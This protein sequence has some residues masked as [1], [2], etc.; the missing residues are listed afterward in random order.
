MP[1][2]VH[3][4]TVNL[5]E[6][7][8]PIYIGGGLLDDDTILKPHLGVGPHVIITNT[9][10]ASLYLSRVEKL[11]GDIP[12]H[13]ITIE[14]GEE[15]KTLDTFNDIIT[16]LLE[17]GAHRKS[18]L[19]ALGGG[20]V[21]DIV[22]FVSASYRRGT[23][24]IQIPTTL[25]AQVDASVGG[26][27]A[28]NHR[29]G[30]NMI[31]AFHQP[32]A[33]VIDTNTLDSLPERHYLAGV[34]EIIKYGL[35]ADEKLFGTIEDSLSDVLARDARILNTLITRS[36][37][38]KADIVAQDE[39]ETG[40]ARMLLNLGHTFGHAIETLLGHGTWLHGEA[41]ACGLV[42]ATQFSQAQGLIDEAQCERAITLIK[43]AGLPSELPEQISTDKMLE[44]MSRDKKNIGAQQTLVLIKS[45][46]DAFVAPDCDTNALRA[47]LDSL[48]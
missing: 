11:L 16:Q 5:K 33:V 24:F 46:G 30:K 27:T 14:D 32:A 26:K 40:G 35:I 45:I 44:A 21:G 23:S 1:N 34:A 39:H 31:G 8:Y 38:I 3:K 41:V 10:V 4:L 25:L 2:D 20:V 36:C 7:S 18:T 42:L 22:G 19:I 9:S 12:F 28:V 48:R 15:H 6:H 13:T 47:F 43:N 29:L 17:C 37:E